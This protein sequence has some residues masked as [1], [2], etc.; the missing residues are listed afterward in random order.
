ML[1]QIHFHHICHSLGPP[2][3]DG[4]WHLGIKLPRALKVV[5]IR[6]LL[7]ASSLDHL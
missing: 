3:T 7:L 5:C 6:D 1:F 4:P 2:L